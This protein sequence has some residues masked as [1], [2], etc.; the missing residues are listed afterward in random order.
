MVFGFCA[1]LLGRGVIVGSGLCDLGCILV[2][3]GVAFLPLTRLR[4]PG[5]G[6][7]RPPP[8]AQSST[9]TV[10]GQLE[11]FWGSRPMQPDTTMAA[12]DNYEPCCPQSA[13][14]AL[15]G[16]RLIHKMALHFV[17]MEIVREVLGEFGIGR[18]YREQAGR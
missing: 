15:Q 16:S 10:V 12:P 18:V 4:R 7:F 1:G 11:G 14:W 8:S 3:T 17:L 5:A 9:D 13:N 6:T 2:G